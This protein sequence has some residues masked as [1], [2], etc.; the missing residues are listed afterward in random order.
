MIIRPLISACL[1]YKSLT[2]SL[3]FPKESQGVNLF[4]AECFNTNVIA[5]SLV[6]L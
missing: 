3:H 2:R 4:R 6:H 5:R 1:N